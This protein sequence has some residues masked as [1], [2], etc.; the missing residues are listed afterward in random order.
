MNF[1]FGKLPVLENT[2][3]GEKKYQSI[4]ILRYLG[5]IYGYYPQDPEEAFKVDEA[6]DSIN[7]V[8]AEMVKIKWEPYEEKQKAMDAEFDNKY[9][10]MWMEAI[11]K[12]KANNTNPNYFVGEKM[13]IA[14]F[15]FAFLIF[16]AFYNELNSNAHKLRQIFD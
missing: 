16:T 12:R 2:K 10:P 4:A 15:H 1:D 8:I 3:T 9:F 6:I 11:E 14:D 13:T 5:S 7:D